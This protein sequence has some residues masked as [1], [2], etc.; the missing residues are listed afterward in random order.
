MRNDAGING[1]AQRIEQLAWILFLKVYASREE[2][3]EY[4]EDDYVSI[5][6]EN[7]RWDNWAKADETGKSLTGDALLDF[8]NNTLFP[9]LKNIEV[10]ASTPIRK[11]I[12]KTVFEESNQ[13]MKDYNHF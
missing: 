4:T 8:V 12:V 13:Y 10:D 6:P 2:E 11:S 1:D 9:T 7:C 3:W 5:I